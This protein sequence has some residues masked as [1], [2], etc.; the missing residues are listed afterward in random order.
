MRV[1]AALFALSLR[2]NLKNPIIVGL[3]VAVPVVLIFVLSEALKEVFPLGRAYEYFIVLVLT[4]AVAFGGF[5]G[6]NG[7]QKERR[8]GTLLRLRLAPTGAWAVVLGAWTGSFVS[9]WLFIVLVAAF[10]MLFFQAS[11]AVSLSTGIAVL[12]A[13]CSFAVSVGT[14]IG[15]AVEKNEAASGLMNLAAPLIILA[16]GGYAPIPE[17]GLVSRLALVSPLRWMNRALAGEL[18]AAPAV[19]VGLGSA[20]ALLV[21]SRLVVGRLFR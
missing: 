10:A 11:L 4:Q 18:A 9:L 1:A 19:A 7:V 16:S 8:H 12:G 17:E 2:E 5:I 15:V 6:L 20:V 21:A 14:L 13:G 3:L